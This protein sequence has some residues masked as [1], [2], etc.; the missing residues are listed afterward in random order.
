M[1]VAFPAHEITL[2]RGGILWIEME[3]PHFCWAWAWVSESAADLAYRSRTGA[4]LR[5]TLRCDSAPAKTSA[6]QVVPASRTASVSP[7][8]VSKAVEARPST[9]RSRARPST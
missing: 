7:M 6:S 9:R 5:T 4:A 2:Q 8:P 3:Y 1:A